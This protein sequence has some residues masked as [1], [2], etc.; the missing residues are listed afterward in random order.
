MRLGPVVQGHLRQFGGQQAGV[1]AGGEPVGGP[2][3]VFVLAPGQG[4]EEFGQ[5]VRG[6]GEL[7]VGLGAGGEGE[8]FPDVVVGV[9]VC[10][11]G[12]PAEAEPV[13]AGQGEA[14]AQASDQEAP[15]RSSGS[16]GASGATSPTPPASSGRFRL[17]DVGYGKC[18]AVSYLNAVFATCA[19][20]PATNWTAKAGSG[21]SYMLYNESAGQCLSVNFNQLYMANCDSTASQS[22][23]TGTS[24]TVVNLYSSACLDESSGW[25]VLASCEPSKSTQ[26]WAKE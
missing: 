18:L 9:G 5:G 20:S 26:H 14:L 7:V 15:A 22:W 25:P 24:S 6:G 17:R 19:D 11:V 16:G 12:E 3:A 4:A 2:G 21:G 13:V 23:R 8:G 1:E 10:G